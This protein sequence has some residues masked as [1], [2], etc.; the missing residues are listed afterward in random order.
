MPIRAFVSDLL[1]LKAAAIEGL[2]DWD[3]CYTD[4]EKIKPSEVGQICDWLTNKSNAGASMWG[5]LH[6][7]CIQMKESIMQM[8]HLLCLAETPSCST[9]WNL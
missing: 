6:W 9:S 4:L 5:I 7:K 1:V 2:D 8:Y 3:L